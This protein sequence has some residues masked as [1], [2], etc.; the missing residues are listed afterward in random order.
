MNDSQ[1]KDVKF[2][3]TLFL[4]FDC[5]KALSYKIIANYL[6]P[7]VQIVSVIYTIVYLYLG[8]V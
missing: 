5:S 8:I 2:E 1:C 7:I 4:K 3:D 6:T